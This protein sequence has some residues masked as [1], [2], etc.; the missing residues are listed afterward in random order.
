MVLATEPYN[1]SLFLWRLLASRDP[2]E[3]YYLVHLFPGHQR[4]DQA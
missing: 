3:Y 2:L 4:L 1:H